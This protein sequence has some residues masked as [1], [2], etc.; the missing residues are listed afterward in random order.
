MFQAKYKT[1]EN[2]SDG[3]LSL[4]PLEDVEDVSEEVMV[5]F[6]SMCFLIKDNY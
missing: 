6:F 2:A 5:H 3:V 4:H 1:L